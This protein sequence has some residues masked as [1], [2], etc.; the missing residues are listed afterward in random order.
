MRL[1][2][3]KPLKTVE[4]RKQARRIKE[5]PPVNSSTGGRAS[6]PV[7]TS[8]SHSV[9]NTGQ[10]NEIVGYIP[11]RGEFEV[12]YDNDA[13]LL[14]AEMEFND[15]DT[16]EE[17]NMKYKLLD[18][19]NYK[20][21]ERIKRKEFVISRQLLDIK[22]Q[23]QL[24]KNRTK[25]EREI[26]NMMK[27][28]ARFNTPEDH[29]KLVEG[30]IKEKQLRQRIEELRQYKKLGLKNFAQVEEFLEEKRK[31][32]EIRIKKQKTTESSYLYDNKVP[33]S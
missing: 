23:T 3:A 8:N 14:L 26:Y 7:S 31:K 20:L 19:Y 13:E 5:E 1:S 32:D 24:E 30:I 4:S 17:R 33:L 15:D 29:E 10:A 28:F 6:I 11:K 21:N 18:I 27:V 2:T 16:E 9:V 25:D 22:Y 12:E